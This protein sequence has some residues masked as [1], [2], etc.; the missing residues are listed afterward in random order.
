VPCAERP[1]VGAYVVEKMAGV[2]E[3][4]RGLRAK[5]EASLVSSI[6]LHFFISATNEYHLHEICE[7]LSFHTF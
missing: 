6:P 4:V 5:A 7:L 3:K 2:V 1:S